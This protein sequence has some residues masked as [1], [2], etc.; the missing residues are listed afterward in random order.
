M[1]RNELEEVKSIEQ[2][3]NIKK[4]DIKYFEKILQKRIISNILRKYLKSLTLL[5]I[6]RM[7]HRRST[8]FLSKLGSTKP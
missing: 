5:N 7:T 2:V 3:E 8:Y 6:M 1:G 4:D